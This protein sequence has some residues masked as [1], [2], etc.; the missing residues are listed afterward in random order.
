MEYFPG[1][2]KQLVSY[3]TLIFKGPKM[4]IKSYIHNRT[5]YEEFFSKIYLLS[6]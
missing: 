2:V 5:S 1:H 3:K 6:Y 4:K